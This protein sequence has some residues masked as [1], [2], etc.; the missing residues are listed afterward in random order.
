MTIRHLRIFIA[1]FD[2]MNITRAAE[3]LHLTQPVVTRTIKEL[4]QYYGIALFER[5]NHKLRPTDAGRRFYAHAMQVVSS[6]DA[7]ETDVRDYAERFTLCV[8]STYYLGSYF[9]PK[10]I[11]LF[12]ARFPQASI[13]ARVMNAGNLQRAIREG[14]LDFAIIEDMA[15]EADLASEL[16]FEDHLTLLLPV[17]HPLARRESV[18]ICDLRDQPFLMRESGSITRRRLDETFAMHGFA[19]EPLLEST[20]THAII[21]CVAAGLGVTLLPEYLVRDSVSSGLVACR[22]ICDETFLRKN[23]IVWRKE[24]HLSEAVQETMAL[25]RTAVQQFHEN[26]PREFPFAL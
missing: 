12:Q 6:F 19:V 11:T 15:T 25:C 24:K 14:E 7:M 20:S 4:E 1:V 8:G 18:N 10:L 2:R 17:D 16:F 5:I 9:L 26:L 21:Q 23:Y 22:P 13:R 3:T